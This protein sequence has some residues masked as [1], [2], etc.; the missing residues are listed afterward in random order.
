VLTNPKMISQGL[1]TLEIVKISKYLII[2]R[3]QKEIELLRSDIHRASA[4][5]DHA[6]EKVGLILKWVTQKIMK[7]LGY[8]E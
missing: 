5:Q 6:L 1:G 7:A 2:K 8:T 3:L 4:K